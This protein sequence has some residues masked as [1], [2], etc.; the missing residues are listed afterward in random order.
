MRLVGFITELPYER[1]TLFE[2]P[3]AVGCTGL[4][5]ESALQLCRKAVDLSSFSSRFTSIA[6]SFRHLIPQMTNIGR[7]SRGVAITKPL[8]VTAQWRYPSGD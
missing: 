6:N 7:R 5:I 2:D 4:C 8:D 1:F 3:I